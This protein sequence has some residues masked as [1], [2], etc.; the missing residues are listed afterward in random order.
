MKWRVRDIHIYV[1]RYCWVTSVS[2]NVYAMRWYARHK[3]ES[4]CV[5][6]TLKLKT[7]FVSHSRFKNKLISVK[8]NFHPTYF[9]NVAVIHPV[10]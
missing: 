6:C 8:P 4:L 7:I 3:C 2:P 10:Y 5:Y 1:L 9:I